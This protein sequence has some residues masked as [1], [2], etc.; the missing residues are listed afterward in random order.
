[1]KKK[2]ERRV[3]FAERCFGWDGLFAGLMNARAKL[4]VEEEHTGNVSFVGKVELLRDNG[5]DYELRITME[6]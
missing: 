6:R 5:V 2:R 4:F 1:M 3:L